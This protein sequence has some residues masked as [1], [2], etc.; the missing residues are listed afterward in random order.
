[1]QNLQLLLIELNREYGDAGD[2]SPGRLRLG[3]RPTLI[4]SA[5][6]AKTTGIVAVAVLAAS[7]E[8]LPPLA[9]M[10]A[11]LRLTRSAAIAGNCS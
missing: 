3:T 10:A 1:V 7:A 4:G 8:T 9:T 6:N 11:T 2:I 5:P